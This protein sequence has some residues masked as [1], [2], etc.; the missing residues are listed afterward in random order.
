[1]AARIGHTSNLV[2]ICAILSTVMPGLGPGIH[3]LLHR[4]KKGVDGRD[5]PGQ[6]DVDGLR[7]QT[8]VSPHSAAVALCSVAAARS[9]AMISSLIACTSSTVG[10]NFSRNSSMPMS[11]YRISCA[12]TWSGRPMQPD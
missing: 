4:R 12:R 6:D 1:M 10:T 7:T 3:V 9:G 5:K 8:N 2:H 11:E